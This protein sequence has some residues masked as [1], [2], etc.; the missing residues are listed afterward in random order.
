MI[1]SAIIVALGST[2]FAQPANAQYD[3][4]TAIVDGRNGDVAVVR[5]EID[6]NCGPLVRTYRAGTFTYV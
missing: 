1:L 4:R 6:C 5:H 3:R 2:P